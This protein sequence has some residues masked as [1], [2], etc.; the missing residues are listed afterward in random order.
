MR[1]IISLQDNLLERA[2]EQ[3]LRRKSVLQ[4][5][6]QYAAAAPGFHDSNH[7]EKDLESGTF[8]VWD[9]PSRDPART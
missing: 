3:A 1:T 5:I 4:K 6:E 7:S 9:E 8:E 2:K